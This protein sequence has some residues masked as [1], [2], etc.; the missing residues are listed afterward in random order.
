M[1]EQRP[2]NCITSSRATSTISGEKPVL[3][4][5]VSIRKSN[6][7]LVRIGFSKVSN[8]SIPDGDIQLRFREFGNVTARKGFSRQSDGI[9]NW[10]RS[11]N[12][13]IEYRIQKTFSGPNQIDITNQTN[14]SGIVPLPAYGGEV[15]VAFE[16]A[17]KGYLGSRFGYIGEFQTKSIQ[18]GCQEI[19][20]VIPEDAELIKPP[21]HI[22]RILNETAF[23]LPVGRAYE[24]VRIFVYP[25]SIGE[26]EGFV[27]SAEYG[28]DSGPEIIIQEN[29]SLGGPVKFVW[30]HE[31]V[32]TRQSFSLTPELEW[33]REASANYYAY[34]AALDSG[35][36]TPRE[37]DALLASSYRQNYS[38]RLID[39]SDS[40][41]AYV[42]GPLVLSRIDS[43]MRSKTNQTLLDTFRWINYAETE[44]EGIS[45][46]EFRN[47]TMRG[48]Q[49]DK[50]TS[51]VIHLNQS[52]SGNQ[53]P[54][55]VYVT[56]PH[57]LP[58]L[59]RQL[60][61][62]KYYRLLKELYSTIAVLWVFLVG[63][64]IAQRYGHLEPDQQK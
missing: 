26:M 23:R 3:L 39:N 18:S 42:W 32:H 60:Y 9:Y 1:P 14:R 30:R 29:A 45:V 17:Q 63:I 51:T 21:A 36:I 20:L 35:A 40:Q 54:R 10:D 4:G 2:E 13:W 7:T 52:I 38:H 56:G 47:H 31:Y 16:A 25:G 64:N 24:Q 53:P 34:R 49:D 5:D 8:R 61:L 6:G 19:T 59:V 28:E 50:Q 33:F 15:P 48:M 46:E 37:Y 44:R 22:L 27:R 58:E 12:P 41:I 55:P 43:E 11:S 57:W 62:P